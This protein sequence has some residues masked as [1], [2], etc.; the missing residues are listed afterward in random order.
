MHGRMFSSISPGP[1]RWTTEHL[2]P[3]LSVVT[4]RHVSRGC[5]M[6]PRG[7]NPHCG[8]L[9]SAMRNGL[10]YHS[11]G[12][13]E[14]A[15]GEEQAKPPQKNTN[16]VQTNKQNQGPLFIEHLRCAQ[17]CH[18]LFLILPT[19]LQRSVIFPSDIYRQGNSARLDSL[20]R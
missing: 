9:G 14:D 12:V 10:G 18:G 11:T 5:Q 16:R 1:P 19:T 17:H 2:F 3:P 15:A 7:Q 13:W 8:E 6:S 4:T 20:F